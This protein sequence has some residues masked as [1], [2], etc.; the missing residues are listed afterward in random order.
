MTESQLKQWR[1]ENLDSKSP[2]FCAHKWYYA[3]VQL[4]RGGTQS[5]FHNPA[6]HVTEEE[7]ISNPRALHNTEQKRIERT[8]MINGQR[9]SG[10]NFCW[11]IEDIGA[12]AISDR[13]R[14]SHNNYTKEEL[15]QAFSADPLLD[16]NLKELEIAFDRTCQLAC[17]YCS[18]HI[19]SSWA[20]DIRKNGSYLNIKTTDQ[21][22]SAR[23]DTVKYDYND[24][25]PY[26]DAFFRWWESDLHK[27][28]KSIHF[29]GGEPTMSGHLWKFLE[30][31]TKLE[32]TSLENISIIT[33]L[34]YDIDVVERLIDLTKRIPVNVS[35]LLSI[36]NLSNKAEYVREGLS[37]D[38]FETN[39]NAMA[40]S[41]VFSNLH[42]QSTINA[43]S[44]DGYSEYVDWL[45]KKLGQ[46]R[47]TS[48]STYINYVRTPAF[49][50]IVVLPQEIR[51]EYANNIRLGAERFSDDNRLQMIR[52]ADY[53]ISANVERIGG[54]DIIKLRSDFK[55]FFV[56]YDQRRNLSLTATFPTLAEWYKTL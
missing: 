11:A 19:S 45:S 1:I 17:S 3:T 29:T 8:M 40:N 37:W 26:T 5:C 9:P 51:E 46:F 10:C 2:T 31:C 32:N 6:H 4:W 30:W 16:V 43:I 55:E 18:P 56:Q 14:Y 33:N 15:D 25:N 7:V 34:S 22:A 54:G 12:D 49:Q 50:N 47:N 41:G 27:T 44:I 13:I 35:I 20:R 23:D 39:F 42:L 53:L 28:L 36:E 38:K 48:L 24:N 21:Y 52:L